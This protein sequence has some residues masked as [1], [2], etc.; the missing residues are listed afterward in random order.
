MPPGDRRGGVSANSAQTV[1][2]ML[3][4]VRRRSLIALTPG[5]NR[6]VL[7]FAQE[8]VSKLDIVLLLLL[9]EADVSHVGVPLLA[10]RSVWRR[11][12]LQTSGRVVIGMSRGVEVVFVFKHQV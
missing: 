1:E 9:A 2:A 4:H 12:G 5:R 7:L 3:Q 11:S 10:E 6:R 8:R